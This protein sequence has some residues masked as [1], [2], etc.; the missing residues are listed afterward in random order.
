MGRFIGSVKT[1]ERI[2]GKVLVWLT[3][4]NLWLL[5]FLQHR[6]G[7][8]LNIELEMEKLENGAWAHIWY[9]DTTRRTL[10]TTLGVASPSALSDVALKPNINNHKTMLKGLKDWGGRALNCRG[11]QFD[12]QQCMVPILF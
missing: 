8:L 3:R 12:P 4:F 10:S 11:S 9:P 1:E 5:W 6:Q 2:Q 7:S